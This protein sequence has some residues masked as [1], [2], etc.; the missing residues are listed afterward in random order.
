[1]LL[2]YYT[3]K[4]MYSKLIYLKRYL[5]IN[6]IIILLNSSLLLNAFIVK[7]PLNYSKIEVAKFELVSAS[8][9]RNDR[10]VGLYNYYNL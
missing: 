10:L 4:L 3:I 7:I 2:L 5:N 8:K 9:R 1:M 6:Y